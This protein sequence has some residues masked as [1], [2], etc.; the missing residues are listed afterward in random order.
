MEAGRLFHT[1]GLVWLDARSPKI[2]FNLGILY[3]SLLVDES[4]GRVVAVAAIC[5]IA[6][7]VRRLLWLLL[8]CSRHS[9]SCSW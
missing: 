5:T 1:A 4:P 3:T 7:V 6:E 9:S 2:L 8:Y